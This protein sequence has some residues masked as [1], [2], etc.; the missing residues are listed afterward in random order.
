[1]VVRREMSLNMNCQLAETAEST[2][3]RVEIFE[4]AM[5]SRLVV[6]PFGPLR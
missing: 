2:Q 1:M 5:I 3:G 6:L 4:L